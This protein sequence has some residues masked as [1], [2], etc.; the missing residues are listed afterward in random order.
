M[1]LPNRLKE[2]L[3][4]A[5]REIQPPQDLKQK[6]MSEIAPS[7]RVNKLKKRILTGLIAACLV[8]PT[9]AIAYQ[10]LYA[11]ELYG[12][13]DNVKKHLGAATIEGYMLFNAKLS[14]AKGE[15][16]SED[17]EEFKELLKV[18]TASKLEYGDA[19]GNIDYG[20]V[21]NQKVVEI[22]DALMVI[23]P[24]FDK[25]NGQASSKEVLTIEEYE[26]Y[27]NSL[28]TYETIIV[29]SG[30][31]PSERFEL[32]AIKPELLDDFKAAREFMS[33]VD[34]K[35]NGDVEEVSVSD[36]F[37][38]F[39]INNQ[40]VQI[41]Y[42]M[43][44]SSSSTSNL[45]DL[46][47]VQT[48]STVLKPIEVEANSLLSISFDKQVEIVEI[49]LWDKDHIIENINLNTINLPHKSGEYQILLKSTWNDNKRMYIINVT[50]K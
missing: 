30:I 50:V 19:N 25:L 22:K 28:M 4:D 23:Q 8:I 45:S 14:Q 27:I 1:S 37:P 17:Y 10:A 15:L 16:G 26:Q 33:Y 43:P 13:F 6:I 12:S 2:S 20:Q 7:G 24:F 3:L 32:E 21:P 40:K 46:E 35:Q 39:S 44:S 9:G 29:Q 38:N 5:G 11:D 48:Y 18:I 42:G 36:P 31:T 47:V 49:Q 34:D 41:D